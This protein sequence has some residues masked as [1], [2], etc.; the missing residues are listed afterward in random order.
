MP[1]F[2]APF[3]RGAYWVQTGLK[4]PVYVVTVAEGGRKSGSEE[5]E[6]V[7]M[8]SLGHPEIY[9][10]VLTTKTQEIFSCRIDEDL[11]DEQ[12][13]KLIKKQ[14]ILADFQNR[15]AVS[16]FYPVKKIIQEYP[17]DEILVVYDKD[18]EFGLNFYV[19]GTEEGKENYLNPPEAQEEQDEDHIPEEIYDY[20]PP[21]SKPWVSL[22]SEK[23]I[24]E[25]SVTTS[26]EQITYM[27]SRKRADFGAPI[28]FSDHNASSV[29]DAYIECTAY[30]DK[31]FVIKQ[32][33]KDVGMQV[34]PEIK[35]IS[36]QTRWTYP[37]NATTQYYP[38]E[39]LEKEKEIFGQSK[40]LADFLNN[41]S[42]SVE[43]ALQQ[44]EITNTFIDDWKTLVEEEGT[45]GDK[46]DTHLKEYQSFTD[47]HN[48]MEKMVTCV[49]WHPN[50]YGLIAVSVAVRLSFEERVYFSGKLLLQ[51][52][53]ILFWSFSDPIHP[54]LMLESP[55]DIFCFKFCPSNPN[56]I[57]GGCINGQI[58]LWDITAHAS[59]IEHVKT[60]SSRSKKATLK[61]LTIWSDWG[62]R[63][64][65]VQLAAAA[66]I[67]PQEQGEVEKPSGMIRADSRCSHSLTALSDQDW[68]QVLAAGGSGASKSSGCEQR[69]WHQQQVR[70]LGETMAQAGALVPVL[71]S[72]ASW[73]DTEQSAL[74]EPGKAL[75]SQEVRF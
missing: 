43:I 38:R 67:T 58:I 9:P 70:A 65:Q 46:T 63:H 37:R 7:N 3:A 22:G 64:Q 29:K 10:L 5:A 72:A 62:Q 30:P 44:N 66:Q 24:E 71:P 69:L 19:I 21:V 45:F 55:D 8:E 1:Y 73:E 12:P 48:L 56:I 18:F 33:E 54:Q 68:R 20:K 14:D 42:T 53:L 50:I 59:R 51:P 32:L 61:P 35:D 13:Y 52:S 39:F 2:R 75:P 49:S 31:N 36:T 28:K 34:V 60:G 4:D 25:E 27:I 17:G 47:L 11:T 26:T 74:R 40:P 6:P 23:E 41:M 16:D 15:A 57:A